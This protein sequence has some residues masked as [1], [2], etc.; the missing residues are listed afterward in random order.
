MPQET[1]V[2]N[3]LITNQRDST[4]DKAIN[5]TGEILVQANITVY[6]REMEQTH[7]TDLVKYQSV[8]SAEVPSIGRRVVLI[9]TKP[10]SII[11]FWWMK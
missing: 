4:K 1:I 3:L 5:Q 7:Q 10:N 11:H 2:S 8:Q 6:P 9:K